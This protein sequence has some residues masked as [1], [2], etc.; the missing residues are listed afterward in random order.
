MKKLLFMGALLIV[1]ATS[2]GAVTDVFNG[3]TGATTGSDLSA[4]ATLKLSASGS[5]ID[6][7]GRAL[8]VVTPVGTEGADGESL[9]FNFS[10]AITGQRQNLQARFTAEI[11]A[12]D[13][14][15][16]FP[17][18]GPTVIFEKSTAATGSPAIENNR[19]SK[20]EVSDNG[21]NEQIGTLSYTLQGVMT[22]PQKYTGTVTATLD[23]TEVGSFI[24][25]SAQIKVSVSALTYNGKQGAP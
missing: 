21:T 10:D 15:L 9:S 7:T 1:G 19:I 12:D 20:I 6:S 16:D 3:A 18:N 5:I 13:K 25:K 24:D 11:I 23:A 22:N 2:F 4:E 14:N 17:A 8:L